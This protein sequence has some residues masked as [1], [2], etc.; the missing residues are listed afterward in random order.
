MKGTSTNG[1]GSNDGQTHAARFAKVFDGRKQ[2]I[3]GLWIRGDR[4][5]A[6]LTVENPVNGAKSVKRI[7]LTDKDGNPVSSTATAVAAMESL[8]VKRA[9]NDLP[10]LRRT[11]K[12]SDFVVTYLDFAKRSKKTGTAAKEETIL[13]RWSEHLGPSLRLDQI[14][15]AHVSAF[16]TKR[17]KAEAN[18]RTVNLDVIALRCA[19]KQART[20]GWIQ[21][22]PMDG[23]KPLKT[24]TPRKTLVTVTDIERICQAAFDKGEDGSPITKNAQQFADYVRLLAYCGARRN[25]ALRLR[26]QD[27]DFAKEHLHIGSDGNTKNRTGRTVDF[28]PKLK[29]HLQDMKKRKAPDSD[30]LFPSPH[31]GDKDASTKTFKESLNMVRAH[32]KMPWFNFHDCRH[33]FISMCV[34]AGIDYMTIAAWVGHK[35]GGILIGKVYGHLA[36]EH[37]QNMA[38]KLN[39]EPT[40]LT[41][42]N[43]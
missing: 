37:R 28:N 17:L 29:T 3:R 9:D 14:K 34:M 4:Y 30:W 19:M 15:P 38:A 27:V 42:V 41:A 13:A 35:D 7:P 11:P 6:Q 21:R 10:N 32:A 20:D 33:T 36:N 8:R 5:Y 43:Q 23:F 39:L 18:P 16:I 22:L 2:P 24:T 12:F 40:V 31:R 25:E 1:T 26:W